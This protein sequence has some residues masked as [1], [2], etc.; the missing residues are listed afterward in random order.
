MRPVPASHWDTWESGDFT[1]DYH[2]HARVTIETTPVTERT[3]WR[4]LQFADHI[5]LEIEL[6][7]VKTITINRS[8][9]GESGTMSLTLVNTRPL[10]TATAGT[11][12]GEPGYL[13]Y[14][15][16]TSPNAVKRWGNYANEYRDLIIPNKVIRTYQ[17]YGTSGSGKPRDDTSLVLTGVWLIDTVDFKADGT[18][19]IECRDPAKL[20]IEQ[21]LLPPIVPGDKY[22]VY[23]LG[24]YWTPDGT[25]T[26]DGETQDG[27]LSGGQVLKDLS[28]HRSG[29][30]SDF[31]FEV[32]QNNYVR[33]GHRPSHVS[34]ND[35]TTY[36]VAHGSDGP[37]GAGTDDF[38]YVAVDCGDALIDQV[39]ILPKWGS[40]HVYVSV[41][42]YD[43]ALGK[44]RWV[45]YGTEAEAT[46]YTVKSGDTLSAIAASFGVS[47]LD[48]IEANPQIAD[49]DLIFP[50]D[51]I[52]I[53]VEGGQP[54]VPYEGSENFFKVPYV[55]D[56]KLT[57]R[58]TWQVIELPEKVAARSV[59]LTF[60]D[61]NEE[62]DFTNK[63]V[64]GGSYNVAIYQIECVN[65]DGPLVAPEYTFRSY[66]YSNQITDYTDV[67]KLMCGWSGFWWPTQKGGPDDPLTRA[68]SDNRV[69][70]F[71]GDFQGTGAYPVD[72]PEL[73]PS[74]FDNKSPLEV[75][76]ALR[77]VTGFI[78]YVDSTG[79][80]VWRTPNIWQK[81]N[82]IT[83]NGYV[84]DFVPTVDEDKVLIDYG[85]RITDQNLRS[86]I[87][88]QAFDGDESIQSAYQPDHAGGERFSSYT[89]SDRKIL[90]GQERVMTVTNYPF[91]NQDEMD[92]FAYLTSLWMHWSIRNSSMRI[93]GIAAFEPDDQIRVYERVTSETFVHYIT[94]VTSTMDLTQG[95]WYMDLDTHWLGEGPGESWLVNRDDAHPALIAW[96]EKMG[97]I[98]EGDDGVEYDLTPPPYE[99]DYPREDDTV[100]D[101][102]EPTPL[103]EPVVPDPPPP[104]PGQASLGSAAWMNWY[105]GQLPETPSRSDI[106]STQIVGTIGKWSISNG[107]TVKSFMTNL[108]VSKVWAAVGQL[109]AEGNIPLITCSSY[110]CRPVIRADGTYSTT[111][112][113]NHAWGL[114]LDIN[115]WQPGWGYGKGY[116]PNADS[117]WLGR[118]VGRIKVGGERAV[119]WGGNWRTPDYMH[120]YIIV[121]PN[122]LW[123]ADFEVTID[124]A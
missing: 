53:P 64:R 97:Y 52:N 115:G 2:P 27:L 78:F 96:L 86:L 79:A 4:L 106:C 59:R 113:S 49:P 45:N 58:E 28:Y 3:P 120:F 1:G 26:I 107:V 117:S 81:G 68:W 103:P 60:T 94:S 77:E 10:D 76:N 62:W 65:S 61:L 110:S 57:D 44:G 39:R 108:Y 29:A 11:I 21:K 124:A 73:P 92:K 83:F 123:N 6:K 90:G 31:W 51:V 23:V 34:D 36:W 87:L 84:P 119:A 48:L 40:Y 43:K 80:A 98:I 9:S 85:I 121:T 24:P 75:I 74:Y 99:G 111:N 17:G 22:P 5:P 20:L 16:G 18:I 122:Q 89:L 63:P 82:Y 14:N 109:M 70:G 95:T 118:N 72:P 71:W 116:L 19:Q 56:K 37:G 55:A 8:L 25:E 33:Y 102:P 91:L 13:T 46:Q 66:E 7:T 88:V 104:P 38:H 30:D 67:V 32:P 105:W 114:A 42:T 69:G 12:I 47:L 93:P 54:I 112:W 15:R 35:L 41:W 101:P 100:L 50:G